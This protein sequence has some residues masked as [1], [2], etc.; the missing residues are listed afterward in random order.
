MLADK[1]PG[2][3]CH[4]DANEKVNTLITHAQAYL[5]QKGEWDSMDK[6]AFA[7]A[8]CSRIDRFTGGIVIIAKTEPAMHI[9][10]QKIRDHEIEKHYLCIL[11]GTMTP[12]SGMLTSYIA[13]DASKKRVTV[14]DH[15]AQG[16]QRAQTRYQTVETRG[17][18]SLVE[19]ELLTGRTHQIRAQFASKGHPLLGDGQYG[20]PKRSERY[21]RSY[22]ALYAYRIVFRFTSD[23]GVLN[24]LNGKSWH[25]KTVPFVQQYFPER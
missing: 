5:Y 12:P 9:L 13:K 2:M 8:L 7:P 17:A 22:Q 14:L 6:N 15:P 20:D 4:P 1:R 24:D 11:H 23:A 19:C 25:V 21:H 16:A 10:N 18:L 3:V